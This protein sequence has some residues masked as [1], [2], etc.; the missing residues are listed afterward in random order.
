LR[1]AYADESGDTGYEFATGSSSHFILTILLPLDP[2]A[3]I[4]RVAEARRQLHKPE[5]FEFHFRESTEQIRHIFFGNLASEKFSALIAVIH[6]RRAPLELRRRGKSGLYIWA[7][8][9][10]AL[11]APFALDQVKLHLDGARSQKRFVQ[12]LKVG[13]RETCRIAQ[14]PEQNFKEIRVLESAHP[15]IQCADMLTGAS[16]QHVET[17]YSLWWAMLHPEPAIW[18]E[19]KFEE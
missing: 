12:L 15:L 11:R 4:D 13:V 8:G 6:K 19:E 17:G 7:I 16:A 5:T 14:R 2:E 18:W 3:L 1:T 9:G 10:L